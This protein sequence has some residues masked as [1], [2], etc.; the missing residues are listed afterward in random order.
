M[1]G[2]GGFKTRQK[3]PAEQVP[4]TV[5]LFPTLQKLPAVQ[6]LGSE[7]PAGHI[8][9]AGHTPGGQ[10]SDSYHVMPIE[11]SQDDEGINKL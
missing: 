11:T 7:V 8:L 6:S 2:G 5:P 1:E 9:P 4:S 3:L 10:R